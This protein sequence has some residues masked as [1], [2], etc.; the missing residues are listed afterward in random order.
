MI[1]ELNKE[2]NARVA[3][4]KSSR[5]VLSEKSTGFASTSSKSVDTMD[6]IY[7]AGWIID[8]EDPWKSDDTLTVG[9]TKTPDYTNGRCD[10]CDS[11]VNADLV[12]TNVDC[13]RKI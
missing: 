9:S 1:E 5:D 4:L 12:C 13:P 3:A 10:I 2:Q 8:G 7:I 11:G 6:L